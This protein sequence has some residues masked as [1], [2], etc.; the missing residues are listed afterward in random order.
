MPLSS[1]TKSLFI[2]AMILQQE[3]FL[4][5]PVWHLCVCNR[6]G[7]SLPPCVSLHSQ[8]SRLFSGSYFPY[9]ALFLFVIILYSGGQ[10]GYIFS[11]LYCQ[12]ALL[13][14]QASRH[15]PASM[16]QTASLLCRLPGQDDHLTSILPYT[17]GAEQ[18]LFWG[19]TG[20][21]EQG[22]VSTET[23]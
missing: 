13:S 7:A 14:A 1:A 16:D 2:P 22:D 23:I 10:F 8:V 3:F 9:T 18:V 15:R 11:L 20:Q 6:I 21:L 17:P 19:G 5:V 4:P 12:S